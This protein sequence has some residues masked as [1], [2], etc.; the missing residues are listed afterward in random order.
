M[1]MMTFFETLKKRWYI[2]IAILGIIIILLHW[3]GYITIFETEH[4]STLYLY[5][6]NRSVIPLGYI[7]HLTEE[8]FNLFPK[9]APVIRDQ[10]QKPLQILDDGE[11]LY[12]IPL[13]QEEY[14]LFNSHYL[15]FDPAM[16]M[17]G[18]RSFE[19]NGKYY[20]YLPP[21]IS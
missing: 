8:D 5:E 3:F 13:T 12:T 2:F 4:F 19:Y 20:N 11:R 14:Y 9:L 1:H 16:N 15:P 21:P 17:E 6:Q 7:T 10:N 18:G